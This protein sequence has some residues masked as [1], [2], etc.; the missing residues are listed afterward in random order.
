MLFEDIDEPKYKDAQGNE[1]KLEELHTYPLRTL[2][3]CLYHYVTE[4]ILFG[5]VVQ[6]FN[7]RE[8]DDFE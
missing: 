2:K 6:L 8:Y 5:D 4:S 3:F 7:A 1:V